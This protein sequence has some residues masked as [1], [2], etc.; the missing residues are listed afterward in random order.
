MPRRAYWVFRWLASP[1]WKAQNDGVMRP[2]KIRK[3]ETPDVNP[4]KF[5]FFPR[6]KS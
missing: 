1:V 6:L 2:P 5:I 3:N 4:N